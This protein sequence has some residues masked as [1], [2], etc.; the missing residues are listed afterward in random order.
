M[1]LFKW[2]KG[3]QKNCD[4]KKFTLWYFKIWKMGFDAYILSYKP[5]QILPTHMDPVEGGSHYRLNIGWGKSKLLVK[6]KIWDVNW[7]K[8]SIILFRPDLYSHSLV[9][10]K[11]TRKL[12]FGFVKYN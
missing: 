6:S 9:I 10:N 7:G 5:N 3:R 2:V 4:Y 11:P 12:S 8:L 1:K